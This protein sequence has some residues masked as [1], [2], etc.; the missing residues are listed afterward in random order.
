MTD[1]FRRIRETRIVDFAKVAAH[2]TAAHL[3]ASVVDAKRARDIAD[4]HGVT[5]PPVPKAPDVPAWA[6]GARDTLADT[7]NAEGLAEAV[8]QAI[9]ALPEA[10]QATRRTT[11][12]TTT[13]RPAPTPA[14]VRVVAPTPP[15]PEPTPPPTDAEAPEAPRETGAEALRHALRV[16][17]APVPTTWT[18]HSTDTQL[19]Q[20]AAGEAIRLAIAHAMPL[21]SPAAMDPATLRDWAFDAVALLGRYVAEGK[22]AD[23]AHAPDAPPPPV[24]DEHHAEAVIVLSD[25]A[26]FRA[27]VTSGNALVRLTSTKTGTSF[28]YRI[29]RADGRGPASYFVGVI[30]HSGRNG[31]TYLGYLDRAGNWKSGHQDDATKAWAWTWGRILAGTLPPALRAEAA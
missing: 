2:L 30:R 21:P 26:A 13:P 8:L 10:K 4:A 31:Y 6:E 29:R 17:L 22:G 1:L 11:R 7:L 14:P 19:R 18:P 28:L 3:R 12:A 25:A 5:F 9:P 16:C 27:H 20:A 15:P 23:V 24:D